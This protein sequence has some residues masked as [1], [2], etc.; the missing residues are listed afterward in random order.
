M[1]ENAALFEKQP[2]GIDVV[3][4]TYPGQESP[5]IFH[6]RNKGTEEVS[7]IDYSVIIGDKEESRHLDVSVRSGTDQVKDVAIPIKGITEPGPYTVGLRVDK[8]NGKENVLKDKV[9][10]YSLQN[11]NSKVESH[12][13]MEVATSPQSDPDF[14]SNAMAMDLAKKAYGDRFIGIAVHWSGPLGVGRQF[15][16]NYD[17]GHDYH[18]LINRNYIT[19]DPAMGYFNAYYDTF[20]PTAK[21]NMLEEALKVVPSVDLKVKG[22]WNADKTQVNATCDVE[23]LTDDERWKNSVFFVLVADGVEAEDG[24]EYNDVMIGSAYGHKS[25][26]GLSSN[27]KAGEKRTYVGEISF[28]KPDAVEDYVD[29]NKVYLVAIACRTSFSPIINAAK[30]KVEE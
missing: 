11:L 2:P 26:E 5:V 1:P 7:S 16:Y 10:Y 12:V 22:E 8:V 30:V 24:S 13:V 9:T 29:K 17:L 25:V 28:E 6:L 15:G 21:V 18:A 19:Y 27:V 20:A 23:I 3:P 14:K 4:S